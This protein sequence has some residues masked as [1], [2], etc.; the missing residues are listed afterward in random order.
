[1]SDEPTDRSDEQADRPETRP[2]RAAGPA[3][4]TDDPFERLGDE[5]RDGDPFDRLPDAVGDD[6]AGPGASSGDHPD[7]PGPARDGGSRE[8]PGEDRPAASV[9]DDPDGSGSDPGEAVERPGGT[10]TDPLRDVETPAG[11]P[12][13]GESSVFERVDTGRA[14]PDSV[15]AALTDDADEATAPDAS[16]RSRYSEVSKHRYCERCEYFSAPPAVACAHESAE[17]IEFRD[18]ETVRLLNCPVVA[19]REA[20][21]RDE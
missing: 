10:A 9:A 18:G 1:M 7:G 4:P 17:I 5:E 15:W 6:G 13:D 20:L 11:S 19:E 8:P 21:E 14:D 16:D 12:F 2:D 3:E